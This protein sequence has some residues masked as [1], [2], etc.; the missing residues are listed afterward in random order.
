MKL[1]CVCETRDLFWDIAQSIQFLLWSRKY[2][3]P[4]F[5]GDV[6]MRRS[7]DFLGLVSDNVNIWH[8]RIFLNDAFARSNDAS[9]LQA[10]VSVGFANI[11]DRA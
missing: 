4:I 1:S 9:A 7:D 10:E 11:F 5:T 2:K 8:D 3:G 6:L